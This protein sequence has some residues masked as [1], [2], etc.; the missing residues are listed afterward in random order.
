MKTARCRQLRQF[1]FLCLVFCVICAGR[2][3]AAGKQKSLPVPEVVSVTSDSYNALRVVWKPAAGAES[4]TVYYK[5]GNISKW[6]AVRSGIRTTEFLHVSSSKKPLTTGTAYTYCVQAV[7]GDQKSPLGKSTR[8]GTPVPRTVRTISVRECA[9]N[10]LRIRWQ[11][12]PG[13]SGYRIYRL[14]KKRWA[15]VA[16]VRPTL[17]SWVHGSGKLHPIVPETRYIYQV[18]A[19]TKVGNR[20]IMGKSSGGV[21]GKTTKHQYWENSG[22]ARY[23]YLHGKKVTGWNTI[24]G[25]QYYFD[26]SGRMKT[27]WLISGKYC[28]FFD[29][30]GVYRQDLSANDSRESDSFGTAE[31]KTYRRAAAIVDSITDSSMSREKKLWVCF[32]Y[33]IDTWPGRNIYPYYGVDWPVEYANDMFL[34]GSGDCLSYAAAFAYMAKACGCETVYGC[35]STG[36]GWVEINDLVYDPETYRNTSYKYYAVP[37]E[38]A[39]GYRRAISHSMPFMHVEI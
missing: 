23:Y 9:C 27:G 17:C 35:N 12:V 33:V 26:S 19:F 2:V 18:R 4:Y 7:K 5:G 34:D 10:K 11:R 31:Q 30:N 36:H 29:N 24:N 21:V 39:P 28:F 16:D 15:K 32:K 3:S 25:K 6:K 14:E 37:Y 8:S 13:A 20:M 22:G 38:S 1:L